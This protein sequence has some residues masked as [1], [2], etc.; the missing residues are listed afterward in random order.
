MDR[1]EFLTDHDGPV[2]AGSG[3]SGAGDEPYLFSWPGKEQAR[4]LAS[5]PAV[6]ALR[7]RP[8][9]SLEFDDGGHAVIEGDNLAVLRHLLKGY[10]GRFKM[11]YIDPPYNTGRAFQYPDNYRDHL[12]LHRQRLGADAEPEGRYHA[13]WLSMMYPRLILARELLREDGVLFVSI[14]DHEVHG[15][16]MMLDEI[17]GSRNFFAMF[18]W[19]SRTSRQNDTDL[20]V[21]HEYVLG[22]AR[23]RR[24]T[25]R[26]LKPD[27]EKLWHEVPGFA[28]YPERVDASRYRNTDNDPRGPWKADPFDAPN[29]RPRLTYPIRNPNTGEEF[30]P[31]PGR[32]WRTGPE[33][34]EALRAEG[35]IVFGRG[36]RSRP[37]LKVFLEEK[38][39]FGEVAATW[40]D[41]ARFGTANCGTRELQTLFDGD[42]PFRY[43]KP[44]ALLRF[45]LR[46]ATGP[47]DL[48]MDFFAGS[49]TTGHAVMAENRVDGGR[50]RCLLVQLPEPTGDDRWPTLADL[51]AER[52]RRAAKALPSC[53]GFR[54][55]R[56]TPD[57]PVQPNPWWWLAELGLPLDA[58]LEALD[59]EGT[60]AY[61]LHHDERCWLLCDAVRLDVAALERLLAP[62]P[63]ILV[64]A[65]AALTANPA[66]EQ[67]LAGRDGEPVPVLKVV[68]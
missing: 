2:S 49:G 38:R 56:H 46:L 33:R 36:G 63:D 19:Q 14:D 16:R 62:R 52:L 40:L 27:N 43:P 55:W 23:L 54:F 50:R 58:H 41:G 28:A 17:F 37:K 21:Q 24:A 10:R 39:A 67:H 47:D 5:R 53:E 61:R 29:V 45:L 12:F 25:H 35:R 48:V 13:R 3:S 7:A 18:P 20:C 42:S 65:G 15:L 11:I 22:Y 26:R 68:E 66:L 34:F 6:G 1:R 9:R 57:R 44:I 8:E 31:P 51:T 4:R 60:T 30:W 59:L 64:L 32:C